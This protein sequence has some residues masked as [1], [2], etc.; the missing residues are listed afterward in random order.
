MKIFDLF[1]IETHLIQHNPR[2]LTANRTSPYCCKFQP[3]AM[4][5]HVE[6]EEMER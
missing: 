1:G 5:V 6:K 4:S 2:E 3:D